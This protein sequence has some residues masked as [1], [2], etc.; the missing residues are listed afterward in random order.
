MIINYLK[1]NYIYILK[2]VLVGITTLLLNIVLVSFFYDFL[3][4]ERSSAITISYIVTLLVH[5]LLNGKF[6]FSS[7]L[8]LDNL[9]RYSLLPIINYFIAISM[10]YFVVEV[11]SLKIQYS[12]IASS[13]CSAFISFLYLRYITFNKKI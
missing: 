4:Y 12:V 2:F 7:K 1:N 5:Y 11:I 6:T 9:V 10:G 13:M 8:G 3:A